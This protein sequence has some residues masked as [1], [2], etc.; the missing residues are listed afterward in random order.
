MGRNASAPGAAIPTGG[1]GH[2][3]RLSL[4]EDCAHALEFLGQSGDDLLAVLA[5]CGRLDFPPGKAHFVHPEGADIGGCASQRVSVLAKGRGVRRF[6]RGR[7]LGEGGGG[8][9][10][11]LARQFVDEIGASKAL[12]GIESGMIDGRCTGRRRRTAAEL[13]C[14]ERGRRPGALD[15]RHCRERFD[16]RRRPHRFGNQVEKSC[17]FAPRPKFRARIRCE[18]QDGPGRPVREGTPKDP[19]SGDV[20]PVAAGIDIHHHDIECGVHLDRRRNVVSRRNIIPGPDEHPAN[21]LPVG[22]VGLN[23]E[24]GRVA[25]DGH[26]SAHRQGPVLVDANARCPVLRRWESR[27][28]VLARGLMHHPLALRWSWSDGA[29]VRGLGL[30]RAIACGARPPSGLRVHAEKREWDFCARRPERHADCT[31]NGG[32]ASKARNSSAGIGLPK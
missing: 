19:C 25:A 13:L 2:A 10:H 26:R 29:P 14:F 11:E 18:C 22:A 12:E 20:L 31:T 4:F 30:G 9:L 32:F 15:R 27:L 16:Q 24:H 3:R 6:H 7:K 17:T 23:Q 28:P 8:V 1:G 21:H 5:Q